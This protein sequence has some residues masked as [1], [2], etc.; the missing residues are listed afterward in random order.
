MLEHGGRLR[1]AAKEYNIPLEDWLDLS[2]GINPVPYP[3]PEI[4]I[5]SW[6]RLPEDHDGL[7]EAARIYYKA[8]NVLPLHGSQQAIQILPRLF[9][10]R[11][12][13][14]L[15]PSY[16]EHSSAWQKAGHAVHLFEGSK[17]DEVV[18]TY[19]IVVLINPNNPTGEQFSRDRL[20]EI[21]EQLVKRD[22][23]LIVDEAFMDASP[24]QSVVSYSDRPGLIVLRSLGKFFGLAGA[25]VGF[26][27]AEE[28]VLQHI[29]EEAGPW[30]ISG[31]SRE[32][33]THAFKNIEWQT[34]TRAKLAFDGIRLA[35]VL[36]KAGFT[37][38][39][40]EL[41]QYVLMENAQLIYKNFA[42]QGILLRLFKEPLAIRFGLPATDEQWKRLES[43]LRN[44]R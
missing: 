39:G 3:I 36:R 26:T 43:V 41:F 10:P 5:K 25:R 13:A 15:Y 8:Q 19:D 12:V 6:H 22:G 33:T 2:T 28:K 44:L 14:V 23:A 1:Q 17:L 9:S 29:K 4:T 24:N 42:R 7:E 35:N 31:P 32:V 16:N 30:T 37:P 11:P 40:T 34:A 21:A 18:T 20:L 27:F 38:Q